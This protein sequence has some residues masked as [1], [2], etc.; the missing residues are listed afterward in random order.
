MKKNGKKKALFACFSMKCVVFLFLIITLNGFNQ[1]AIRVID[2]SKNDIKLSEIIK[3][4][5]VIPLSQFYTSNVISSTSLPKILVWKD[6]GEKLAVANFFKMLLI[7]IISGEAHKTF[8]IKN[9]INIFN[10]DDP[11]SPFL[12]HKENND[13][14]FSRLDMKSGKILWSIPSNFTSVYLYKG[15]KGAPRIVFV[16]IR[17]HKIPGAQNIMIYGLVEKK[18]TLFKTKYT[19]RVLIL[20]GDTGKI[21]KDREFDYYRYLQNNIDCL[22]ID[23]KKREFEVINTFN[24]ETHF[25]GIYNIGDL[26]GTKKYLVVAK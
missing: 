21:I 10:S 23:S 20:N 16:P 14:K 25:K 4:T 12:Q 19:C 6:K 11:D 24:G 15:F 17:F 3:E 2:A 13:V 26:L 1:G 18:S 7:N 5:S 22:F 8:E 9:A